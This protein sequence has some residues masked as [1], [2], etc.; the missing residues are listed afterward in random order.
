M[1]NTTFIFVMIICTTFCSTV[2]SSSSLFMDTQ[3]TPKE[4]SGE[5][6]ILIFIFV[7]L[8]SLKFKKELIQKN[9]I[10][11]YTILFI[12]LIAGVEAIYGIFEFI[13]NR[14]LYERRV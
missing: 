13:L 6:G 1:N 7:Y 5:I 11:F 10:S 14:A 2:F 8:Y 3:N 9:K 12:S 4:L